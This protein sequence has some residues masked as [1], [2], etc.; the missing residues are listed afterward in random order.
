[1]KYQADRANNYYEQAF[2][3]LPNE[4]RYQQK[5]GLIMAAIYQTILKEIED[6]NYR[7]MERRISLTPLRKLWIAWKSARKEKKLHKKY[8]A[9]HRN[10]QAQ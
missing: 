9:S 1:M 5:S 7:V 10:D 2:S 4:D 6:D 8:M 3:M